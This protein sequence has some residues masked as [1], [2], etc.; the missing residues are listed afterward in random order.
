V[1]PES[2]GPDGGA[3]GRILV[4]DDDPQMRRLLSTLMSAEGFTCD[5][6]GGLAEARARLLEFDAD[7]VLLD[8]RLPGESGLSLARELAARPDGPAVLIVSGQD[9]AAVAGIA[10]DAG[11]LGYVTKPFRRND[12]TIA[13]QNALRRHRDDRERRAQRAALEDRVIERTAVALDALERLRAANEE[14]VRTLS[15][16]VEFRD[17]ETGSHIERMSHYC[18]MLAVPLGLDPDLLRVASRLHDIGKIA[19]PDSILL[20]PGPLTPDE[21]VEM[22]RHAEIGYWLLRGSSIEVLEHAAMI[23]WTHHERHDG[24]GYPRGLAG[25]D[26]PLAGRIAGVADVF[27]ALT[28]DRV[29]RSA[30][31]VEEAVAV[32]EA[33]RGRQLDP[34]VLDVFLGDLDGVRTIMARFDEQPVER[35]GPEELAEPD[36]V[37]TLQEAAAT[38]GVTTSRLRRWSDEGRLP[39]LR[40]AGGHRRF[41]VEGVRKL[42]AERGARP[43]VRPLEPPSGSL[44][45]LA[46]VL[47]QHG[48]DLANGAA[49]TLYRG[50]PTGWFAGQDAAAARAEWLAELVRSAESGRYAGALQASDVFLRRAY[51]QAAGLLERHSFIERFT[52]VVLHALAQADAPHSETAAARRLF[53]AIQQAHLDG[54]A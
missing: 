16:A 52:R 31:P 17:P 49:T 47:K 30:V 13:V 3:S 45:V 15:K 9:D 7:L 4:V 10:L 1:Q 6:A 21:R 19:T 36:A 43:V 33:Q 11:V 5:V 25:E 40:T 46:G 32:L 14:T 54:R 53:A 44:P 35:T 42:A 18:A 39:S 38:L 34:A 8:V 48:A 41:P 2:N 24:S 20:K 23:A 28:T 29:Y 37:M 50:G 51:L 26:I 22:E 12:V 27:D